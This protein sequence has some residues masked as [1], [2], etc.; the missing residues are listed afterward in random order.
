MSDLLK[1]ALMLG[2]AIVTATSIVTCFSP[3]NSCVRAYEGSGPAKIVCA[4]MLG[5]AV[6][7]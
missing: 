5:R 3:Y 4:R 2:V 7:D 1:A 6:L